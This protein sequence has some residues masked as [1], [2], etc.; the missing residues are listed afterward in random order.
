M[1]VV[2]KCPKCDKVLNDF[3]INKLWCTNCDTRYK[4]IE[5]I[6]IK[7]EEFQK[8]IDLYNNFMVTT[9]NCYEGYKIKTYIDTISSEVFLGTGLLSEL[10]VHI[11]DMFGTSSNEFE[12]KIAEAKQE[13]R[14]KIVKKA[15]E[16]GGN[17]IVGFSLTF[18]VMNSNSIIVSAVGTAVVIEK[19]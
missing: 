9:T 14:N 4:S 3:E 10:S 6:T 1:A 11:N 17:A 16:L 12:S 19:Q 7:N 18:F 2:V 15:I 8:Q 13:A 5:E